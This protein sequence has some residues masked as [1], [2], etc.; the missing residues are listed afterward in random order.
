M[1][2]RTVD[3]SLYT[4]PANIEQQL[5][6]TLD[7]SFADVLQ[8]A[9]VTD[10]RDA[11]YLASEIVMHHLRRTRDDA[12]DLR[13]S[14]LYPIVEARFLKGFPSS[15]TYSDGQWI[16]DDQLQR[17]R[18]DQ[19][20]AFV[21]LLLLD[22]QSYEERLDFYEVMFEL[23]VKRRRN[24]A[25]K[26]YYRRKKTADT[27]DVYEESA[28]SPEIEAAMAEIQTL[29]QSQDES[30]FR[31][32]LRRAIDLLPDNE[33]QVIDM[34]LIGIPAEGKDSSD[35]SISKLLKCDPRTVRNRRN[36]AIERLR[37]TLGI[38][39]SL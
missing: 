33:R 38:G 32:E 19:L 35:D 6:T 17:M 1:R 24:D 21:N 9:A 18:D 27:V 14:A 13:F 4:R 11:D 2:K 28:H 29:F 39:E 3:G 8:R 23:T 10:T 16:E 7:W 30:V 36:R 26:A 31:F 34:W 12:D 15:H 22:R 5:G 20:D 37:K 25:F